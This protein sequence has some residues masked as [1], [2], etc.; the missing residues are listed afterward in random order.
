[1]VAAMRWGLVPSWFKG[2]DPPKLQFNTASCCSDTITEKRSFKVPLGKGRRCVVLADGFCE[3]QPCQARRQR[4]PYFIY[5]PQ[6]KTKVREPG[7]CKGLNAIHPR[8]PA[9]LNGEEAVSKW[10]DFGEVLGQEALRFSHP[11]ENIT[12]HP[13]SPLVNDSRNSTPECLLPVD[14]LVKKEQQ[15]ED[16]AMAGHKVTQKGRPPNTPK[17]SEELVSVRKSGGL[18][19]ELPSEHIVGGADQRSSGIPVGILDSWNKLRHK[20]GRLKRKRR[21]R[22]SECRYKPIRL[23]S[24][25]H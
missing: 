6:I 18:V 24:K 8:R 12:F 14:L 25:D 5:F 13:V 3:R 11:T 4:Q 1:M 9:I 2:A 21:H 20:P 15:P 7:S 22:V 10:L 19:P 23:T 17:V 16:T